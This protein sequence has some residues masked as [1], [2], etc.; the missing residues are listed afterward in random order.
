MQKIIIALVT[1]LITVLL[2]ISTYYTKKQFEKIDILF[3]SQTAHLIEFAHIS[4][5]LQYIK[6]DINKMSNRLER[7]DRRSYLYWPEAQ[8]EKAEK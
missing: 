7:L 4:T 2:G 3:T 8:H 5:E 1:G 6:V